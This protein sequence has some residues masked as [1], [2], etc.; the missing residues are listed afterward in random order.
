MQI[1]K[2]PKGLGCYLWKIA[3][4]TSTASW[5][6]CYQSVSILKFPFLSNEFSIIGILVSTISFSGVMPFHVC[7]HLGGL[8]VLGPSF[9]GS[10][11][12]VLFIVTFTI[13]ISLGSIRKWSIIFYRKIRRIKISENLIHPSTFLESFSFLVNIWSHAGRPLLL[14]ICK[15]CWIILKRF[16]LISPK[17]GCKAKFLTLGKRKKVILAR[18]D[19]D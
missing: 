17:Y 6:G 13:S 18:C 8:H 1:T 5:K 11:G 10:Y 16:F 7:H 15:I 14:I 2:P 3:K 19:I 4:M 9:C 12:P